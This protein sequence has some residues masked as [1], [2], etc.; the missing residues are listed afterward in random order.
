MYAEVRLDSCPRWLIQSWIEPLILCQDTKANDTCLERNSRVWLGRWQAGYCNGGWLGVVAPK[1]RGPNFLRGG[2]F[3]FD[4][5]FIW[6]PFVLN[7]RTSIST[8]LSSLSHL[9][10][11]QIEKNDY[12]DGWLENNCHYLQ[13]CCW[14][15]N[16][17]KIF[18][19]R[20]L[21]KPL[22]LSLIISF[23]I[24]WQP[25]TTDTVAV[26]YDIYKIMWH[27]ALLGDKESCI[28]SLR[29][30][31]VS[32][33]TFALLRSFSPFKYDGYSIRK[34][35]Q[36]IVHLK[37]PFK[38]TFVFTSIMISFIAG[39][40]CCCADYLRTDGRKRD[41]LAPLFTWHW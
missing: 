2:H 14:R 35:S 8:L 4:L 11:V 18:H 31:P 17:I 37:C 9:G 29:L 1:K 21:R 38:C 19:I 30:F 39:K 40:P 27:F 24:L 26:Q 16:T 33:H 41:I 3:Y 7:S 13:G 25:S 20:G 10:F 6:A 12:F 34:K 23:K 28:S 36:D 32:P 5:F 15:E 22:S